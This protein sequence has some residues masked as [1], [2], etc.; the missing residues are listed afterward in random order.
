MKSLNFA[1]IWI[2][3]VLVIFAGTFASP[4]T[5][6]AAM[7][8]SAALKKARDTWGAFGM[9]GTERDIVQSNWTRFVGF[10]SAGCKDDL[11]RVGVGNN[12]WDAAYTAMPADKGIGATVKGTA[13]LK[14]DSPGVAGPPTP[15]IVEPAPGVIISVQIMIDNK[16]VGTA[17]PQGTPTVWTAS[18]PWDTT[19]VPNGFHVMC[20][21]LIHGDGSLARTHAT[22]LN[23]NQ[24]AL[25][26]DTSPT[27]QYALNKKETEVYSNLYPGPIPTLAVQGTGPQ[28]QLIQPLNPTPPLPTGIARSFSEWPPK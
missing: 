19:T 11:T 27:Y 5:T 10:K 2:T 20:A 28:P 22:L 24:A 6:L 14:V 23:V 18:I 4:L 21:M 13:T 9:I 16:L 3:I 25:A 7:S 12:T 17:F 1:I 8:D 26:S 15:V